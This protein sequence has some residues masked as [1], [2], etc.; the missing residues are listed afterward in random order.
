MA[1]GRASA[2][3]V[4]IAPDRVAVLQSTVP[5]YDRDSCRKALAATVALYADL[6]ERLAPA[7]LMRRA[8]AERAVRDFLLM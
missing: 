3:R 6:R 4:T 8:D 1:G 7:A 2:R 5:S